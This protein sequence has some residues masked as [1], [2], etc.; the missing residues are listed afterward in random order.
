[1]S[2]IRYSREV[3]LA[4]LN[5][6]HTFAVLAVPPGSRVLDLGAAD[7]SVARVLQA[8]GCTVTA[9]ERDPAGVRRSRNTAS[10]SCRPISTRSTR[11]TCRAATSTCPPA[12]RPRASRRPG[13]AAGSRAAWLAPGGRVLISVPNVA[14]AAVRLVAAAGALPAH[15]HRAARSH[16]PA[17]LRPL[18]TGPAPDRS[19]TARLDVLTV[20]RAATRRNCRC[21]PEDLGRRRRGN[22]RRSALTRLPVLRHRRARGRIAGRW[23][24]PSGAGEPHAQYRD[25]VPRPRGPR[26]PYRCGLYRTPRCYDQRVAACGRV[27]GLPRDAGPR[28]RQPIRTQGRAP[29]RAGA[30]RRTPSDAALDTQAG[31][32]ETHDLTADRDLRRSWPSGWGSCTRRTRRS[33]RCCATSRCSASSRPRWPRRSRKSPPAVGKRGCSPSSI[34]QRVAPTPA[35]APSWPARP[36]SSAGCSGRSRSGAGALDA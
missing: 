18:A 14:H 7:G 34:V 27:L 16:A 25:R 17:F 4:D 29:R 8:R 13:S 6:A 3:D 1:M 23:R 31:P 19:G 2:V 11:T 26:H 28:S 9:V 20:E 30:L 24:A 35:A 32:E 5:N 36:P 12:R 22:R 10:R 33:W 15:R 21:R